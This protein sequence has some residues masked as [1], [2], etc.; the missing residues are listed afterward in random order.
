MRPAMWCAAVCLAI[1][2]A[3]PLRA[4]ETPADTFALSGAAES[5]STVS[6]ESGASASPDDVRHGPQLSQPR[7]QVPSPLAPSVAPTDH[8]PQPTLP[9]VPDPPTDFLELN[10]KSIRTTTENDRATFSVAEGDVTA[11]YRDFVVTARRAEID[12]RTDIAVCEGNVVL[13]T[14]VQEAR[15]DRATINLR[16]REWMCTD[17]SS[18]VTPEYAR[19]W[20]EAPAFLRSRE[21]QGLGKR[22]VHASGAEA[23]TCDLSNPHYEFRSRS[24]SVYPGHKMVL[25]DVTMYA[26]GRRLFTLPRFVIPLR[27]IERNPRVIPSIGRSEEEGYFLKTAYSWMDTRAQTGLFILDLMSK[28]GVGQGLRHS[29]RTA[30]A[31][32]DAQVYHISD[33]NIQLDTFTGRLTHSQ[34]IGTVKASLSTD[35]RSNSYVYAPESKTLVN[36]VTLTRDRTGANTSLALTQTVNNTSLLRTSNLSAYLRHRQLFGQAASLDSDFDYTSFKSTG[37]RARLSSQMLFSK[38]EQKFDWSVSA[39]KL[40]DL[41]DEAFA[42]QG[43]FAGIEKLPEIGLV[44]DTTKLGDF[45][46]FH[47]PARLRVTNGYYVEL[48]ATT[49]LNRTFFEINSPVQRHN[50]TDTWSLGMGAGFKQY[51]YSDNTAQ[52]SVDASAEISKRV[53]PASSFDLT[54]RLQK[55]KGF[56]PFRFDYVGKYNIATASLNVQDSERV[57]FSLLSGYNFDQPQFPWQDITFRLSLQPTNSLLLYTATG[58]DLNRSEWRTLINQLR[59]RAGERMRLDVGTRY[60]T[61]RKHLAACRVVLDTGLDRLTR[62]Q[63]VGSYNGFTKEFDY[64][65][66]MLTRDLHCWEAS[67]VYTRQTG[68]YESQGISLNLRI[69]AFPYFRDFGAGQFGQALDTSVGQVY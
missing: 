40:T 43:V 37:T 41:S 67:L 56:A 64:S 33:R 51:F 15:G 23:T 21:L 57:R 13:R 38:R 59:V 22:E 35:L 17:S 3:G 4:Q 31:S 9:E 16:T 10:A 48:P 14:G 12:H 47:I 66:V 26:L 69:K 5:D 55:P 20:L 60:D 7:G 34:A 25:R 45:L 63:A 2:A 27:E 19:G 42:G 62:L 53:G 50:F 18:V 39:Q 8:V 36:R 58:Y 65:S 1:L 32:G 61:I 30:N 54:Y 44:S 52:Y 46:P 28:K 11:R 49:S 24:L 6:A 68:F 29:W